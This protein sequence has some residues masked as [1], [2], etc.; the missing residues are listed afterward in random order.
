MS[1]TR[2]PSVA[3]AAARAP[4]LAGRVLNRFCTRM[5]RGS[6]S[7]TL[8]D[9]RTLLHQGSEPGPHAQLTL[10][11]WRALA[12]LAWR[13]DLGFAEGYIAGDW[14][15]T[16]LVRMIALGAVNLDAIDPAID[17]P[18]PVRMLRRLVHAARAN[19]IRGSRRNITFHYDLGNAFYRPWLDRSMTYSSAMALLPG[20]TLEAAQADK[21]DRI[22][23]L[24][25]LAPQHRVLEIG[26]GWGALARHIA[27]HCAHV[28]G[29]TL[30]D[31]Q[32]ALAR[33]RAERAGLADKLGFALTDYRH[34][35]GSFDRIASIEMIEA[36]GE[37]WWPTW[38]RQVH[39]RLV[40]GGRAVVQAITIAEQRFPHYRQ[41]P[42]FIQH[43]VFP[44]GMLP[45][46]AIIAEQAR[47]AGLVLS[48]QECF[49]AGYAATLAEWRRRFLGA[50]A[51]LAELGFDERFMRLWTYYLSYCEAGFATGQ[52][53][54]GLYV[55]ER[56]A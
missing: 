55:L 33:E 20:Q 4:G 30:S 26:C 44:G 37:A 12:R 23:A 43:Y 22:A 13:G 53:D 51:T 14:S 40:P 54:V 42:D 6:L 17:G 45:T 29:V 16:D 48:H 41:A 47:A 34:V 5:Q 31:E 49:G 25:D 46:K 1:L 18:W 3:P 21:L 32:L 28:T 35:T 8:P 56:P 7:V 15:S 19:S 36:V 50:R 39:D 11:R 52:T 24:L 38:F 10:H 2:F 9:G 27:P